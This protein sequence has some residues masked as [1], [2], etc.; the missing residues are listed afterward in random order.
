MISGIIG[1][2]TTCV[3]QLFIA[4]FIST[5]CDDIERS[6]AWDT[7]DEIDLCLELVQ[8][9]SDGLGTIHVEIMA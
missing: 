8:R 7:H 6:N 1:K 5:T 9:R 2:E 3:F 4:W